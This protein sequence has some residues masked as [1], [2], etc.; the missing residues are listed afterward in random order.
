[1]S[2]FNILLRSFIILS[3]LALVAR[4]QLSDDKF[5]QRR[6]P[7]LHGMVRS[8]MA[9][10]VSKEPRMG[11]SILRLFFHD[12]FVNGCD[13][14]V[15]LDDTPTFTGEKNVIANKNSAR[16]FEVID[17]IKSAVE[18][19]CKATVSCADI[20]AIAARDSV[21]LLGGPTWKVQLGRRDARTAS[22]SNADSDLPPPF[23]S[24]STLIS[25]FAAKGLNAQEMTVLSGGH[26]I[27]QAHCQAFRNHVYNESNI[28]TQFA[29]LRQTNCPLSGGDTNL[30]P[31][32]SNANVFDNT[33][34]KD[35]VAKK[36]LL[37][38]DQELF[39]GGSQDD[40]V[41]KYSQDKVAFAND[42]A[43]AM[44]KMGSISPLTGTDGEIRVNCRVVN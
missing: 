27:G 43:A 15:L 20:L 24:L 41:K 26:T 8:T 35:L 25:M 11:A 40:L 4:G 22:Q 1:M 16:G 10:A 31:L 34:F 23:A 44:I 29:Q 2:L 14:S 39:N 33:F 6:C 7:S 42:F 28:D 37:H 19:K 12:C 18:A 5:Y 3:S 36:G 21:V 17:D 9:K 13:G 32:D 38:S 30:A